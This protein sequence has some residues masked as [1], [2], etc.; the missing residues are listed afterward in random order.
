MVRQHHYLNR[1]EF[2]Q[3]LGVKDRGAWSVVVHEVTES[4]ATQQLKNNKI[5][6]ILLLFLLLQKTGTKNITTVYVKQC[7]TYVLF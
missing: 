1:H 3:S 2:E 6:L 7:S 4:D 5:Y